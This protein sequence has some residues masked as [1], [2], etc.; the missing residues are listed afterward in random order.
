MEDRIVTREEIVSGLRELGLGK[1]SSL[2]V[3][4]S[5]KS[6]GKVDGGVATLVQALREV[7]G[8]V[9]APA[10]TWQTTFYPEGWEN[11]PRCPSEPTPE[12]I[13]EINASAVPF[14]PE[15][16]PTVSAVGI[17]PEAFRREPDA[18]VGASPTHRFA[19]VGTHAERLVSNQSA[20]A[21]LEPIAELARLGGSILLLGVGH[22]SNTALHLAE[23][24]A[25]RAQWVHWSLMKDGSVVDCITPSCS[26][27]FTDAEPVLREI[28]RETVIGNCRAQLLPLAE[29]LSRVVRLIQQNPNALLCGECLWCRKAA[30]IGLARPGLDR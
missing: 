4:A 19:A 16:T 21:P 25:G 5:L 7:C 15:E 6:F 17:V 12:K 24:Q 8:T 13:A 1:E 18:V 27:A 11:D 10:F 22:T 28:T 3:H 29:T 26:R 30:R 2:V 14:S 9:M 20:K 23:Y